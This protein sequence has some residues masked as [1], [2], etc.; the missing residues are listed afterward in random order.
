MVFGAVQRDG[1]VRTKVN[2]ETNIE[3]IESA[4]EGFIVTGSTMV[5]DEHRAY[6]QVGKKYNHKRVNHNEKEYVRKE[7][8]LVHTNRIEGFWSLLKRQIDGIHHSVSPQHL[9]RNCNEAS[10]RYNHRKALQ[11]ERFAN[12]LANC[13]GSLKY[14]ELTGK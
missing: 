2:P 14:K 12:A 6:N 7:D 13:R 11:D 3:N 5:S 10:F 9:Q 8:I 4:I 1:K